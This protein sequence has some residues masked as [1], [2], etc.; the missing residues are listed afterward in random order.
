MLARTALFER[1]GLFDEEMFSTR[2][3]LDFRLEVARS[4]GTVWFEPSS[5]VTY[6]PGPPFA[7][8][9]VPFFIPRWSDGVGA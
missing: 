8:A 2:E 5:V 1:I 4:G 7:L 6:V 3:H 9:D